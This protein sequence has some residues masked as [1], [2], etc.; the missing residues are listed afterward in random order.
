MDI[1]GII[2]SYKEKCPLDQLEVLQDSV[3]KCLNHNPVV[4]GPSLTASSGFFQ[5][6]VLGQDTLEPQP[7][8]GETQETHNVSCCRDMTQLFL[9]AGGVLGQDTPKPLHITCET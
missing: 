4:L 5:G 3:V 8:T 7:I 9:K 1:S 6:N 2:Q